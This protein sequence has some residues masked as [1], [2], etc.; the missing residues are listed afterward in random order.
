MVSLGTHQDDEA[1]TGEPT[2]VGPGD[3]DAK[4][5]AAGRGVGG[6]RARSAEEKPQASLREEAPSWTA[7]LAAEAPTG[8]RTERHHARDHGHAR[9]GDGWQ[10]ELAAR[11]RQSRAPADAPV[12]GEPGAQKLPTQET[13]PRR[14]EAPPTTRPDQGQARTT[15][16]GASSA[17]GRETGATGGQTRRRAG[18]PAREAGAASSQRSRTAGPSV[19]KT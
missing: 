16:R 3:R 15:S 2:V 19:S 18:T 12:C 7:R 6:A 17:A 9:R 10:E 5:G 8:A 14:K 11:V 1:R 4:G 13:T